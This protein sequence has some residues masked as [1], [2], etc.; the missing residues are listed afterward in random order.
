MDGVDLVD[1]VDDA[2]CGGCG[3]VGGMAADTAAA[4]LWAWGAVGGGAIAP[5]LG[6][7]A[8]GVGRGTR[9]Q[10]SVIRLNPEP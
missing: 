4:T 5:R 6:G 2:W 8:V 9:D 10:R 3:F 7:R 1:G